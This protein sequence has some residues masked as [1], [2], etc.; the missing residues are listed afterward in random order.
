[1]GTQN[2]TRCQAIMYEKSLYKRISPV[3]SVLLYRASTVV[4]SYRSSLLTPRSAR[5]LLRPGL[6]PSF[7][8]PLWRGSRA[9]RSCTSCREE[10]SRFLNRSLPIPVPPRTSAYKIFCCGFHSGQFLKMCS[11]VCVL[12]RHQ[13]HCAV[14]RLFVQFKYCLVRQWPVFSW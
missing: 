1:M 10:R 2:I 3:P 12:Y 7:L 14:A 5:P 13:P 8:H 11:R 6:G 9:P 4:L